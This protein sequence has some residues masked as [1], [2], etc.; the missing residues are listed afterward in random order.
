MKEKNKKQNPVSLL[1]KW[2]DRDRFF[3]ILSV[4][5]AFI[6]GLLAIGV[7]IGIYNIMNALAAG[8]CTRKIILENAI[9]IISTVIVRQLALACSGVSSHKGAYGALFRVRCMV[10]EH[11]AKVPLG[12]LDEKST[13]DIKTV[14]NE[15]IE[16][17]ERGLAH[18]M[19]EFI[20]YCTGPIV[21]FVYLFTVNKQLAL[22]SLLPILAVALI[23]V[24][25]FINMFQLTDRAGRST[26]AFNS[27][28]IEYINGMRQIK[29]Y[30]MGSNS[31]KKYKAAINEENTVWNLM[32]MKTG[33]LYA[34]FMIALE[35]GMIILL[36]IGGKLF[37]QS[38]VSAGIFLLFA[39][40]GSMYLT[41]L[42]PLQQLAMELAQVFSAILKVQA[43]LD[44]PVFEGGAHFPEKTDIAMEHVSFCYENSSKNVLENCN[45]KLAQG[46]KLAIVGISGAGKSTITELISRFYDVKEGSVKIGGMDVREIAY[47]ELLKNTA[48]VFQKSFL[49]SGTVLENIRMGTNASLEDVRR[50]ARLAQIDDYIMSLPQNY[51]TCIGN[52]QSRFSGGEKQ[53]IAIARAILK[54]APIL[55]LDEAT[56]AADPENQAQI[57][58]A[59]KNLC[60]N[61]TVIIVAHRLDVVGMC[62]KVAVVENGTISSF[63][64][65]DEVLK[66]NDYYKNAWKIYKEAHDVTYK[67]A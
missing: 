33:P 5:C 64:T 41:E 1:L 30:N 14:I 2:A 16:K 67:L 15:D 11:L 25:I 52:I 3:L 59:I 19:P 62:D 21:I 50:A 9:L 8:T 47:E 38:S 53:R 22:L 29:A 42:L 39:Y 48:I 36:P 23:M 20:G 17:L 32:S 37:L 13:G 51:D 54:D 24:F 31:F 12:A 60:E 18:N 46:E 7:Y 44:I 34:A 58:L 27:V 61:K 45:L 10:T 28:I 63:G 26:A 35:S 57:D 4:I 40:V 66:E 65:H 6:S 56:S 49:T 43:I 55:I